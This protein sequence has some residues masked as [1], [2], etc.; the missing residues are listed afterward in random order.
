MRYFLLMYALVAAV[1]VGIAGCRGSISRKPPIEIFPDM[2]RQLKL[3]PQQ[4]NGFFPNG[5]SSQLPVPGTVRRAQPVQ[6]VAGPVYPF[7]DAPVNTGRL[8]GST[9]YVELNPMP[10]NGALLRRGQ[11]RFHIYCA[12]CHGPMG[13][14]NGVTRKLGMSVVANLHDQRIVEM[15]D[16]EI[17]NIIT[18]GKNLMQGYAA[19]IPVEDRWAIVAYVRVLQR[20]WLGTPEE[21]P[22]EMRTALERQP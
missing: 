11:E 13:D 19:Q 15:P 20:S 16:G 18:H 6:T 22:A 21:L 5:V 8:P 1:I 4:A 2:D 17:F 9:N 3:R 10:L 7:E 14:G 12:P